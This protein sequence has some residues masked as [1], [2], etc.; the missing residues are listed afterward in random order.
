MSVGHLDDRLGAFGFRAGSATIIVV[1]IIEVA[2]AAL[3]IA[4]DRFQIDTHSILSTFGA[5]FARFF[6]FLN[7]EFGFVAT[8]LHEMVPAAEIGLL[9]AA[10]GCLIAYIWF[11]RSRQMR[12]TSLGLRQVLLIAGAGIIVVPVLLSAVALVVPAALGL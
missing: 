11:E 1:A 8:L 4:G 9:F 5:G 10:V 3:S 12:T 2:A 6:D 7:F